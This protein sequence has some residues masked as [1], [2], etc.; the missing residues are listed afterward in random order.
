MTV[1][2]KKLGRDSEAL[3]ARYLEEKGFQILER[4]FR[5]SLG[6]I[7]LIAQEGKYLVFVEVKSRRSLQYGAPSLAVNWHK[8]RK[9]VQL[10][11]TYLKVKKLIKTSCRFDVV[12]VFAPKDS[13]AQI[14]HIPNAFRIRE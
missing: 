2:R 3:A 10:A 5:C 4:N 7:D 6:E 13:L 11:Q 8:Q 14:K 1:V 9:I 12:S